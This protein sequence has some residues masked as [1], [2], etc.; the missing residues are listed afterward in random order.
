[1]LAHELWETYDSEEEHKK[2]EGLTEKYNNLTIN[3]CCNPWECL[4]DWCCKQIESRDDN[5]VDFLFDKID[6]MS[7]SE[8]I[9]SIKIY[10]KIIRNSVAARDIVRHYT[11]LLR[12]L[13]NNEEI[14]KENDNLRHLL[15]NKLDELSRKK[16]IPSQILIKLC[17]ERF[18]L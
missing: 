16:Y 15:F 14:L 4:C 3:N 17:R 1:M 8:M 6:I 12:L 2:T 10:L 18:L 9:E 5:C 13:D 11:R 7:E